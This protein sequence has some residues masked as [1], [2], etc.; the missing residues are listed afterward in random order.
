MAYTRQYTNGVGW[1]NE[2]STATPINASNLN[3]M[4]N[5]IQNVDAE[6]KRAVDEIIEGVNDLFLRVAGKQDELIFDET[7]TINSDKP[8]TSRGIKAY[9]DGKTEVDAELSNTSHKPVENRAV[10]RAIEAVKV[11]IATQELVG[12]VK[13]DGETIM[14]D[15]DGTIHAVS[16]TG[17]VRLPDVSGASAVIIGGTRNVV[18]KWSDPQD[19][20]VGGETIATWKCTLLVRKL[21]SA[22]TG[23]TDGTLLVTNNV[24]NQYSTYGYT[25]EDLNYGDT[26][27]YRLFPISTDNIVTYGTSLNV[28]VARGVI[29]QLPVPVSSLTYNGSE[30]TM[31]FTNYN[32]N[33]LTASNI[34]ATNAGTYTALFT[35][36]PGYEWWDTTTGA[37]SVTWS[38]A[39]RTITIPTVSGSYT[40]DGTSKSAVISAF[41]ANDITQSGTASASAAGTYTVYFDLVDTDNT[42]WTDN[43][44][45]QK[46]GTWSIGAERVAVPTV[47]TTG[48]TY[49]G[50]SISVTIGTYD[51]NQITVGGTTSATAAGSYT[52]RFTLA[53]GN[54][55]W[56]DGTTGVKS[57]VWT[58]AKLQL[59]K[60]T[61]ASGTITYDGTSKSPTLENYNATY[62]TLSGQTSGTNAG[63]YTLDIDLIDTSDT[64]WSDGTTAQL[65]R[66]WTISKLSL[67]KA[68]ISTPPAN[69][70]TGSTIYCLL[71]NYNPNYMTTS[72]DTSAVNAGTYTAYISLNDTDNTEWSDGTTSDITGTWSIS[73]APG[74][75]TLSANSV[76]LENEIYST[77][78]SYS[79]ATGTVTATSSDTSVCIVYDDIPNKIS[80]EAAGD[81]DG[82]ATI[83][84]SVAAS[85]NYYAIT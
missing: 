17:V 15:P 51:A 50:N 28:T 73:K 72:G 38:I 47:I 14:I 22:P 76:T 26:Y 78:V 42:S 70:Y 71:R 13:P 7:P 74:S 57:V 66:M 21:G 12:K 79:G 25:D 6:A 3:Q 75:I 36:K 58:I 32:T 18:V 59:T 85:Q 27:Y 46:F 9:V 41:D 20:I 81:I 67:T 56:T 63:I 60:P 49:S 31:Q 10:T 29:S 40:Y 19:V 45:T 69:Q 16:G 35:P 2:P 11:P 65:S 4:D 80:I 23:I 48:Y 53:S 8:V 62:M 30:Q 33:E 39:K 52:V 61:I 68:S 82:T 43:T 83:T 64:E 54:L 34:S 37:K 77:F 1:E 24:R 55:E 84:V 5:A 44:I